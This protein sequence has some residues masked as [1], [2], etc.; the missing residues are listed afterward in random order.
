MRNGIIL[1]LLLIFGLLGCSQSDKPKNLIPEEKYVDILVEFQ[2]IHSLNRSRV[3]SL[4]RDSLRKVVLDKYDVTQNQFDASHDYYQ[5]QPEKQTKRIQQALDALH[6]EFNKLNN[7][8]SDT[9]NTQQP[10]SLNR[11]R[12]LGN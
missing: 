11:R 8:Q 3:D 4:Q 5:H 9:T 6:M 7:P 1:L 12:R 2:L 10:D